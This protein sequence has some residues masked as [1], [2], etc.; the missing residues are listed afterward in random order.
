MND[1]PSL[2]KCPCCHDVSPA[3]VIYEHR[4]IPVHSCLLVSNRDDALQFPTGDLRL[5]FCRACGFIWNI[6]FRP[7][8]MR[9]SASYEETQAFSPRFR[10]FQTE[11]VDRWI[12]RYQLRNRQVV[13]IGCGKGD[14]LLELCERGNNTGVGIDPSYRPDRHGERSNERATFRRELY[15]DQHIELECDFIACRHTLEHICD[16]H[17]FV[18]L[19][20]RQA[21]RN[22]NTIVGFE[23]PDVE[24]ILKEQAFWDLYHEH[25]SNFSLESLARLFRLLDFEIL[26]LYREYDDQYL[27][28]E[29]RPV[30]GQPGRPTAEEPVEELARLVTGFQEQIRER[31][32]QWQAFVQGHH[33]AGRRVALWGS[34]S[35]VVAFLNRFGFRDEVSA[36]VDVNPHKHGKFLAVSGHEIVSPMRLQ[37]IKPDVVIAMNPIYEEEIGADLKRLGLDVELVSL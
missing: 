18:K 31:L 22:A 25:C 30:D 10:T 26:D 20:R 12:D 35:K 6:D 36:V 14:F 23:V 13:E 19:V 21:E 8:R 32:D 9:Y 33:L 24:R 5:A 17:S 28:L 15:G 3:D 37:T 27:I 1:E 16:P 4:D 34:G 11:L 29:T 7:G 2:V